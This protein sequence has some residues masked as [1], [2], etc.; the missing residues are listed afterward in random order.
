MT[1]K[2]ET[3]NDEKLNNGSIE[4]G[5]EE[6]P[7]E[8]LT[9]LEVATEEPSESKDNDLVVESVAEPGTEPVKKEGVDTTSWKP[10]TSIGNGVKA[11]EITDLGE[12]L[13][14]GRKIMESEIVDVLLPDSD[15]D[16]LLIGQAKG[17]F[18]GGQ[19]RIFKQTQKKTQ[20]GNKPKFRTCAV[21]GNKN[22]F[23]GLGF[24]KSKETVPAREKAIRNAKLNVMKVRRGCGSWQCGCKSPHS[25]PFEGKGKNGSVEIRLVPAPKGTGLKIEKECAKILSSA[26]IKDVWSFTRGMT[27]TKTN[28]VVAC[29]KA[30]QSLS[31]TK[32]RHEDFNKLG[33]ADGK[34]LE[35]SQ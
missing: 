14:N 1:G 33:I 24:G 3:T 29:M 30:L 26:G 8:K 28:L 9:E 34:I 22:G 31:S 25:I 19:R 13:D 17:K 18:G 2:N 7:V 32:T 4:E 5:K 16:L 6:I 23:V 21:L 15:V 35:E 12:L 27:G 20:E 10:K 11:G